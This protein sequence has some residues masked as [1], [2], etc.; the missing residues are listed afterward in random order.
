MDLEREVKLIHVYP[1]AA[2]VNDEKETTVLGGGCAVIPVWASSGVVAGIERVVFEDQ[3]TLNHVAVL[4]T[5]V[6]MRRILRAR[7]HSYQRCQFATH[8]IF[9]GPGHKDTLK[10]LSPAK[11]SAFREPARVRRGGAQFRSGRAGANSRADS[12]P[13]EHYSVLRR[14]HL[15]REARGHK[16][17]RC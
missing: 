2:V 8:G 13:E 7:Q 6:M 12:K 11:K 5:G 1:I 10:R 14:F 3:I 17:N 9:V 4:Q 15:T 16:W